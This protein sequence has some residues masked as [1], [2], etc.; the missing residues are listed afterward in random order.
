MSSK[1]R[2]MQRKLKREENQ[3]KM[4]SELRKISLGFVS[5]ENQMTL[6]N[7]QTPETIA[8]NEATRKLAE[9]GKKTF[10]HNKGFE[11]I[12]IKFGAVKIPEGLLSELHKPVVQFGKTEAFTEVIRSLVTN[13]GIGFI[14]MSRMADENYKTSLD[15]LRKS[16]EDITNFL[17]V[18]KDVLENEKS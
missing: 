11:G 15:S 13:N 1:N 8:I 7:F 6:E 12:Q 2:K 9:A 18:P 5:W 17:M 3:K 10:E 16:V 14:D 4:I